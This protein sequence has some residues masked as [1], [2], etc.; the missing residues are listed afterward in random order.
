VTQAAGAIAIA[1]L[2][3]VL[4]VMLTPPLAVN[5]GLGYDG[6]FYAEMALAL[7]D[8]TRPLIEPGF[9]FRLLP[10]AIVAIM[11]FDVRT[12]FE[13]LNVFA[14]LGS[15]P[16]VFGLVRRYGA[17]V[18]V[19]YLAVFW[20][21][22]LPMSARWAIYYPVLTDTLAF[23][24][25]MVLIVAALARRYLVFAVALVAGLLTREN[26]IMA[27]PF[28]W[29]SELRRGAV[30]AAVRSG[31]V[32]IPAL[33][34]FFAVQRFPIL[35]PAPISGG[36]FDAH[37]VA[38][39]LAVAMTN[40]ND[41]LWRLL[42]AGPLSLGLLFWLPFATG[43]RTMAFL[44]REVHWGY[45]VILSAAIA[46]I[47][48]FD[49]ARYLYALAP[50]LLLLTF[51][52]GRELWTSPLRA[53]A[54]TVLQLVAVRFGLQTGTSEQ[55]YFQSSIE[56]MDMQRLWMLAGVAIVTFAIATLLVHGWPTDRSS[57]LSAQSEPRP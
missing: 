51:G 12:G 13:L 57:E 48:G 35:P 36:W 8:G 31:L 40:T 47:G 15:A 7:R 43:R 53:G 50:A 22:T 37:H 42:L 49:R 33:V 14:L 17:S 5:A 11:P 27:V 6:R 28:L 29:R 52:V 1:L 2:V 54:L 56:R 30:G 23:F 24:L 44:S 9:A 10:S 18:T 34:V 4:V 20:W 26:L 38:D 16:L 3:L 45:Y 46:F 25:L 21:M 19:A 39:T 41:D 32:A 55:D